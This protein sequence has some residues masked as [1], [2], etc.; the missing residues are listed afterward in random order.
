MSGLKPCVIGLIS[1]A[2]FSLGKAVLFP[3]GFDVSLF[4]NFPIYVPLATFLLCLSLAH[5]KVNPILI[6]CL[7]AVIG[8]AVGYI[9]M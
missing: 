2:I 4:C 8:I 9:P 3:E 6:I 7:S 1:A 5:K